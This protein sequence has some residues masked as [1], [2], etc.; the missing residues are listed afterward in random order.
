MKRNTVEG[1]I[2]VCPSA[3]WEQVARHV[4]TRNGMQCRKKWLF[5]W[6][7]HGQPKR[8]G[9]QD[10]L[11]LLNHLKDEEEVEDEDEVDWQQLSIGWES[12]RSAHSLRMKWAALRR[13]VP[14]YSLKSFEGEVKQVMSK[15]YLLLDADNLDYLV[16][17]LV[18]ALERKF[19]NEIVTDSDEESSSVQ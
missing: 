14:G 4:R 8:W 6:P 12:V 5:T 1:D 10:D 11:R 16:E 19:K 3:T 17:H 13:H 7:G 18:P 9:Y 2:A 15:D